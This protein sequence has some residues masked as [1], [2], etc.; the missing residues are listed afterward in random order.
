MIIQTVVCG[1]IS[2][3]PSEPHMTGKWYKIILPQTTIIA[4][5]TYYSTLIHIE[6]YSGNQHSEGLTPEWVPFA[7][8]LMDTGMF[9]IYINKFSDRCI[10]HTCRGQRST[11]NI[12]TFKSCC[13]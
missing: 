7:S 13:S 1:N 11:I 12:H 8:T 3:I 10:L 6:L 2:G 4:E 9:P 5:P